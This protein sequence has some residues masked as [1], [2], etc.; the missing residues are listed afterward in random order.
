[1]DPKQ[2]LGDRQIDE[3]TGELYY[4]SSWTEY[5]W[6]ATCLVCKGTACLER[7]S[8]RRETPQ[9]SCNARKAAEAQLEKLKLKAA[10]MDARHQQKAVKLAYAT[11]RDR[12]IAEMTAQGHSQSAIGKSLGLTGAAVGYRQKVLGPTPA[13]KGVAV[14]KKYQTADERKEAR[15]VQRLERYKS[16]E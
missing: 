4:D 12:I 5:R 1:V 2:K 10:Q 13:N 11:E 8:L 16:T 7:R 6:S 3:E 15:R 14:N 9:A